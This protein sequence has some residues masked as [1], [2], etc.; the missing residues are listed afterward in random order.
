M[1]FLCLQIPGGP[2]ILTKLKTLCGFFR[3]KAWR[4]T[5]IHNGAASYEGLAKLLK[6]FTAKHI[7][8]RY[9]TM[10]DCLFQLDKLRVFCETVLAIHVKTW[11][12]GFKDGELLLSLH[13]CFNDKELWVFIHV[14][15]VKLFSPLEQTRRWGLMCACC[16]DIREATKQ[17]HHSCINNSRRLPQA[18]KRIAALVDVLST[19][20]RQTHLEFC[21][22]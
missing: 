14:F 22:T 19:Q 7:K 6:S 3:V 20:G 11:F 1:K 17:K 15:S 21:E 18:R 8:W 2:S 10:H 16:E 13:A 5:C 4:K 9:E 12:S